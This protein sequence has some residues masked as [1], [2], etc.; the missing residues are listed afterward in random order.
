MHFGISG[1]ENEHSR[2]RPLAF[3]LSRS[4]RMPRPPPPGIPR[5]RMPCVPSPGFRGF[6]CRAWCVPVRCD[7]SRAHYACLAPARRIAC[8]RAVRR[9]LS[10]KKFDKRAL[11]YTIGFSTRPYGL[12]KHATRRPHAHR[13]PLAARARTPHAALAQSHRELVARTSRTNADERRMT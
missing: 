3:A 11:R 6:A 12:L 9:A 8:F 13:T 2:V 1:P 10:A 5:P 4:F 7:L